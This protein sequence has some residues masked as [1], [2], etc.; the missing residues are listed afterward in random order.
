MIN[1]K[2]GLITGATGFVGSH[3]AKR[4]VRDGWELHVIVRSRS[5]LDILSEVKEKVNIHLYDETMEVILRILA[6]AKPTIV[7]HLAS[8]FIAEHKSHDVDALIKSNILF[9]TQLVEAMVKNDVYKLINTT[10]FWQNYNNEH[11]NPVNLY[12]AT[13]QAF[14]DILKY[15]VESTPLKVI[16]LKLFDTYGPNDP[17][18]KLF[19]LIEEAVREQKSLAMS[20]GEQLIDLVYIDDV[21]DAFIVAMEMLLSGKVTKSDHYMVSSGNPIKLKDLLRIYENI[22]GKKLNIEWGG[23]PYRKR[24]VMVPYNKGK[25]LFGWRPKVDIEK[26]I[27]KMLNVEEC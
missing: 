13:K 15:Y 6:E 20:P 18:P 19:K 25:I 17:R 10:T 7:F 4:L 23:L 26:G 11:Y 5:N 2:I 9:G 8:L 27:R 12:A 14:E 21:V 3:L 1:N 16:N 24:E 22:I